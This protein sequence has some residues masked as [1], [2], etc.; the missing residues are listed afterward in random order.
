MP[1]ISA[2]VLTFNRADLLGEAIASIE[3]QTRPPDEIL[4]LD[5]G[6]TDETRALVESLGSRVRYVYQENRGLPASRNIAVRTVTGELIA[7]LDSDDVWLPG[8]LEKL[9]ARLEQLA[10]PAS[11][12]VMGKLQFVDPQLRPLSQDEDE[13]YAPNFSAMLIPRT[14]WD[15]VGPVDE[16][17]EFSPDVEW[18]IRAG[19]LGVPIERIPDVTLL[20]RRHP[21][22]M[23]QDLAASNRGLAMA[24]R[25][26]MQRRRD[27]AL[28]ADREQPA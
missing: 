10:D 7:F 19:E 22:N 21:G 17:L 13:G 14:V 3:G 9:L 4:I 27:Q 18:Y 25:A 26:S 16:T 8:H 15:R 2:I 12:A 20:Y 24:L 28:A 23:T 1:T 6:S 11:C 5:D